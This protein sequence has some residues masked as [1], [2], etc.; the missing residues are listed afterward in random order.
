[1]LRPGTLDFRG[2]IL[3]TCYVRRHIRGRVGKDLQGDFCREEA[4]R[5]VS[6]ERLPA[7]IPPGPKP[8]ERIKVAMAV[9][10]IHHAKMTATTSV[11]TSARISIYWSHGCR[12]RRRDRDEHTWLSK[13]FHGRSPEALWAGQD[14]VMPAG[15][16]HVPGWRTSGEELVEA[17]AKGGCAGEVCACHYE[18]WNNHLDG[19]DYVDGIDGL[20]VDGWG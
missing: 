16:H 5:S 15:A 10:A 1:M 2:S 20:T 6:C 9:K 11:D 3:A 17:G 18:V 19:V 12:D 14:A 7:A 13:P 8:S 4:T